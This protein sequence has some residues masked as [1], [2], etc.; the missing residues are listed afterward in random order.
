MYRGMKVYILVLLF[1]NLV[2]L[3]PGV[4]NENHVATERAL[5]DAGPRDAG[6]ELHKRLDEA[7]Q[8]ALDIAEEAQHFA[9]EAQKYQASFCILI[10]VKFYTAY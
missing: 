8:K 10:F 2:E 1:I 6:V 9:D 3:K 4:Q 5:T 7:A